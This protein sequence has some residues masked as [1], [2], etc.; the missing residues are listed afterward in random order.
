MSRPSDRLLGLWDATGLVGRGV[1]GML[2]AASAPAA[3]AS[4][5]SRAVHA[6][7]LAVL[8]G[9]WGG[10]VLL[11]GDTA[12]AAAVPGC[13]ALLVAVLSEVPTAAADAGPEG[14]HALPASR[15]SANCA[16]WLL[17]AGEAAS[18]CSSF[19]EY[20]AACLSSGA[21]VRCR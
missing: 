6:L 19:L 20:S 5:G 17:P 11:A 7:L 16:S 10:A 15:L 2:E 8:S 13:C 1:A 21:A 12:A 18:C 3:A 14:A 4:P 9:A